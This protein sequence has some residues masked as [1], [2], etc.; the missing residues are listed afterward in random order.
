MSTITVGERLK[1]LRH[2]L[3][4]SQLK[5]A[6]KFGIKQAALHRYENN[7]AEAPYKTLLKYA[8]YFDVSM[9]YIFGRTDKPEGKL[10]KFKPKISDNEELRLF[11]EMC[12]DPKSPM[13]KKLKSILHNMMD[14][15]LK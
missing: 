8:D 11:I 12:F 9:D 2:S 14:G 3:G 13:N 10:Y 4:I 7:Q 5:L 1:S 15:E 6:N